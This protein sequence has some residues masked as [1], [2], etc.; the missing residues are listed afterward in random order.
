MNQ[1]TN[2]QQA[3]SFIDNSHAA[4]R[5]RKRDVQDR[6]K[7]LGLSWWAIHKAETDYLSH[8]LHPDEVIGGAVYGHSSTES[9]SIMLVATDRRLIVIDV[10]PLF[11][12]SEDISYGVIS[13]VTLEWAGP[14]GII[15][16]HTRL[17]N[18]SVQTMN[19]AS[20]Q[21][22]HDY[23]EQTYIEHVSQV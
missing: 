6:L 3:L 2:M 21:A 23:V 1:F 7:Q 14:S 22:F 8:T 16:L 18:I 10:R 17:G 5:S 20:A 12:K 19:H 15:I 11:S 4:V 9:G 13:G